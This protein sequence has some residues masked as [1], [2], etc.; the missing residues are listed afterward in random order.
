ML[1][2]ERDGQQE[3]TA[4]WPFT[5]DGEEHDIRIDRVMM[6]PDRLQA[7]IEGTIGG[8]LEVTWLDAL[9]AVNRGF[10]AAG[11]VHSV[12]LAGIAHRFS[13]VIPE[14]IRITPGAPGYAAFREAEPSAVD[15]DG[16]VTIRMKGMAAIVPVE[17]ELP[18]VYSVQGPVKRIMEYPLR[19]FDRDVWDVRVTVARIGPEFEKEVDLSILVTDIVLDGG[20]LPQVGDDVAAAIRLQGRIWWPNIKRSA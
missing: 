17:D 10:Y 9:F 12:I 5:A 6:A 7:M 2:T 15:N 1:V 13:V 8:M 11:S 18:T 20:P 14:H 4:L 16:A 3:L 19:L